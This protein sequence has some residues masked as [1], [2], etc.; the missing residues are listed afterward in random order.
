MPLWAFNG[1]SS[2]LSWSSSSSPSSSRSPPSAFP[3][4]GPRRRRLCSTRP[5]DR[6]RCIPHDIA[7]VLLRLVSPYLLP[8]DH[9]RA[10]QTDRWP[11]RAERRADPRT[12]GMCVF[13][14]VRTTALTHD[15]AEKG[16]ESSFHQR[17]APVTLIE[18]KIIVR[19][20][21]LLTIYRHRGSTPL[22]NPVYFPPPALRSLRIIPIV[23]I[24][25]HSQSLI[26]RRP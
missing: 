2:L 11:E 3:S 15:T 5:F 17:R 4:P 9:E 6:S 21:R 18:L 12:F 22:L 14:S 1:P 16:K 13:K 26:R 23:M 20:I 25:R 19:S 24:M 8:R 10:G 7:T